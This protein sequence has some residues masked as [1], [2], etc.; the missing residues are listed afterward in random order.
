MSKE[1]KC[2]METGITRAIAKYLEGLLVRNEV[3]VDLV[4]KLNRVE[5]GF[6]GRAAVGAV[7]SGR[8]QVPVEVSRESGGDCRGRRIWGGGGPRQ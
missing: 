7:R 3:A 1:A 4:V 2:E 5:C 6:Q 8:S